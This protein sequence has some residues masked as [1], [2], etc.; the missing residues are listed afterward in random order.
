MFFSSLRV[1]TLPFKVH[2]PGFVETF[3]G[4]I[5]LEGAVSV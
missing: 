1:T 4:S 3:E 5:G 2:L